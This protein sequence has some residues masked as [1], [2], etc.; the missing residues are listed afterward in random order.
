MAW[1]G[2]LKPRPVRIWPWTRRCTCT[3]PA[4]PT[5]RWAIARRKRCIVWRPDH[6]EAEK[7][8]WAM[9]PGLGSRPICAAARLRSGSLTRLRSAAQRRNAIQEITE[10]NKYPDKFISGLDQNDSSVTLACNQ[11]CENLHPLAQISYSL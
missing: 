6:R 2:S 10:G 11:Y 5:P 3:T 9:K 1:A 8:V 4:A 7:R